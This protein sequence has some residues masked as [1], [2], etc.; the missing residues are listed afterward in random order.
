MVEERIEKKEADIDFVSLASNPFKIDANITMLEPKKK[1]YTKRRK[2]SF[3]DKGMDHD[4]EG[5]FFGALAQASKPPKRVFL[6]K[7]KK[8][9]KDQHAVKLL[10]PQKLM[11]QL[12]EIIMSKN[13]ANDADDRMCLSRQKL[14]DYIYDYYLNLYGTFEIADK[15]VVSLMAS[16]CTHRNFSPRVRAIERFCLLGP[17]PFLSESVLNFYLLCWDTFIAL[18]GN[19]THGSIWHSIVRGDYEVS[20]WIGT[21]IAKRVIVRS[22]LEAEEL[23]DFGPFVLRLQPAEVKA[24]VE[25]IQ[26]LLPTKLD[27]FMDILVAEYLKAGNCI[28]EA[29]EKLFVEKSKK[30][31][32]KGLA[33]DDFKALLFEIDPTLPPVRVTTMFR[34]GCKLSSSSEYMDKNA[35]KLFVQSSRHLLQYAEKDLDDL[36]RK[37][38]EIFRQ[39]KEDLLELQQEWN[40]STAKIDRELL[41]LAKCGCEVIGDDKYYNKAQRC[42]HAF[43]KSLKAAIA[44][45]DASV[46][47][48]SY[49]HLLE[50]IEH[51]MKC[52]SKKA[53]EKAEKDL[54]EQER[55]QNSTTTQAVPRG[56]AK[57]KANYANTISLGASAMWTNMSTSQRARFNA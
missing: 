5:T 55:L 14:T 39:N 42:K 43:I 2:S 51:G 40:K 53:K 22:N 9:T 18:Q 52:V 10:K 12:L 7:G 54:L 31:K 24:S 49:N 11:K 46:G 13:R 16:I 38:N 20:E 44:V 25:Y 34:N 8:K 26:S 48:D 47:W 1:K 36:K 41:V 33:I 57:K 3:E 45:N 56:L 27:V 23:S 35:F 19:N 50:A 21:S 30:S 17:G 28:E 29:M 32:S 6:R 15:R 37:N 4:A